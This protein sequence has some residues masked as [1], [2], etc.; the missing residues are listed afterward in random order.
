L[1]THK[2]PNSH[3]KGLNMNASTCTDRMNLL[4][5]LLDNNARP[6]SLQYNE[7]INKTCEKNNIDNNIMHEHKIIEQ[8][9]TSPS[10]LG[11]K[12]QRDSLCEVFVNCLCPG[13]DVNNMKSKI[14]E[15]EQTKVFSEDNIQEKIRACLQKLEASVNADSLSQLVENTYDNNNI[16]NLKN[17]KDAVAK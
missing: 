11:K 9:N 3:I 7:D 1:N 15:L 17:L 5:G 8:R 6:P 14:K 4:A 10:F 13:M 16:I 2:V 12:V